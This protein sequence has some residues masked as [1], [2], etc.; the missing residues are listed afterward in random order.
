MPFAGTF[1]A[2]AA[3]DYDPPPS[4]SPAGD[5][6]LH[7]CAEIRIRRVIEAAAHAINDLLR[8]RGLV[9]RDRPAGRPQRSLHLFAMT[10]GVDGE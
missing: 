3:A 1:L 4:T 2:R 10:A 7:C 9:Q 8:R 6:E 5:V